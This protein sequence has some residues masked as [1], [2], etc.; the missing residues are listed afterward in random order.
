MD[1]TGYPHARNTLT[2]GSDG[3]RLRRDWSGSVLL[4]QVSL[5]EFSSGSGRD[6]VAER[7]GE[8]VLKEVIAEV[9]RLLGM[10]PQAVR[11]SMAQSRRRL[12]SADRALEIRHEAEPGPS[13]DFYG[14]AEHRWQV[15]HRSSGKVVA[16]FEGGDYGHRWVGVR[17]V[18]FSEDGTTLI[19]TS[20]N[21]EERIAIPP[22]LA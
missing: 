5:D 17:E 12:L 7:F 1:P 9:E 11:K 22:P 21:A 10:H 4:S 20:E 2:V 14:V 18:C 3:V 16:R 6:V 8:E 13:D 15:V 19:V